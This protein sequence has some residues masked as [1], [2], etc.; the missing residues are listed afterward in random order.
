MT[1][2]SPDGIPIPDSVRSFLDDTRYASIATLDPDGMPR[3]V[4]T[5]YTL[6][7]DAII[8]SSAVGRR[9][10]TNLLRDPRMSLTVIDAADA[11]RW[12]GMTGIATR[13]GDQARAQA[14]IAGMARRYRVNDPEGAERTIVERYQRQERISFRFRP[15]TIYD[16]DDR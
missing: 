6:E 11:Y 12:V 16:Y 3:P 5:W 14:D 10:P 7:G 1:D 2:Q 8:L 15:L 4:V 13:I 9:W